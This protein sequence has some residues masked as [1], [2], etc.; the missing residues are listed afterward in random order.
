MRKLSLIAANIF[1]AA[2]VLFTSCKTEDDSMS[3]EINSV[4]KDGFV[5]GSADLE[6]GET[7]KVAITAQKLDKNFTTFSITAE[8]ANGTGITPVIG[9]ITGFEDSDVEFTGST[10]DVDGADRDGFTIDVTMVAPESEGIFTYM[11]TV[12]DRDDNTGTLSITINTTDGEGE[13]SEINAY[14]A[15]LL[16]VPQSSTLGTF[17]DA[18]FN[19]VYKISDAKN[20]A[21]SV[22]FGYFYG[23]TNFA[24]LAAPI[25]TEWDAFSTSFSGLGPDSWSTRNNTK[26]MSSVADFDTVTDAEIAAMD[27]STGTTNKVNALSEGS[28]VAFQ[29]VEGKKG[30]IEVA[31][32]ATG[33]TSS[34]SITINIKVQ[35]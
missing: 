21:S 24:T 3:I 10:M 28:V 12:T 23:A 27:F 15:T 11:F 19:S 8:D 35:K 17:M 26:F 6:P 1:I 4:A 16:G 29:T 32:I 5:T 2:T 30:L 34:G 33:S 25:A 13:A 14:S 9:N 20:N 22:D 7:F 31:D 18:D